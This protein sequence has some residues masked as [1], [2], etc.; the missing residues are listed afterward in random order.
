MVGVAAAPECPVA[1]ELR[2]STLVSCSSTLCD[3]PNRVRRSTSCG[4]VVSPP[5]ECMGVACLMCRPERC[6]RRRERRRTWSDCA[7]DRRGGGLHSSRL[8]R[9]AVRGAFACTPHHGHNKRTRA[10]QA[11]TDKQM[12]VM[13]GHS[14]VLRVTQKDAEIGTRGRSLCASVLDRRVSA[15]AKCFIA[16]RADVRASCR[17]CEPLQRFVVWMFGW[18]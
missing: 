11:R 2:R 8:A 16:G 5:E 13:P 15:S 18:W 3:S 6:H 4:C 12:R 7:I 10:A 1:G 17:Q 14:E 9:A